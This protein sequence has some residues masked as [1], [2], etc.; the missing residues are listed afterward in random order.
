ME[1]LP[2]WKIAF[3]RLCTHFSLGRLYVL[4]YLVAVAFLHWIALV[5]N[6][7][8]GCVL[9]WTLSFRV[10]GGL[11]VGVRF[12][13]GCFAYWCELTRVICYVGVLIPVLDRVLGVV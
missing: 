6:L 11:R 13:L 12:V 1:L 8:F 10:C 5:L 9:G 2:G 3:G 4:Y 7:G